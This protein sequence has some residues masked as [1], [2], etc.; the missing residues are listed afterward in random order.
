MGDRESRDVLKALE[1]TPKKEDVKDKK[2]HSSYGYNHHQSHGVKITSLEMALKNTVIMEDSNFQD[3]KDE[4]RNEE[5]FHPVYRKISLINGQINR[6]DIAAMRRKCKELNLNTFGKRDALKRRLKEYYKVEMLIEAGLIEEQKTRLGTNPDYFIVIDFEA[7]C[8]EKNPSGYPHEIIEFPAVLVSTSLKQIV[9]IFHSYVRPV[10]NPTLSEFCKTLTGIDQRVVDQSDPF[11]AVNG[12]FIQWLKDRQIG[13]KHS[14]ILITDG[15]FD[16][17]RFLYLQT[18]QSKIPYP[19]Y[20]ATSWSNLRKTFSNFYRMTQKKGSNEPKLPSLQCMLESLDL[21]FEG[22][23]HSGLDDSKNIARILIRLI[24]DRAIIRVNEKIVNVSPENEDD[25]RG[26][27]R[28]NN[29]VS[30]NRKEAEN[31]LKQ[32]RKVCLNYSNT[33][34][35]STSNR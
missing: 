8:E 30:V 6:M 35:H 16:M 32:Q 20:Y 22:S 18:K 4:N 34:D 2:S 1:R 13:T 14:F 5:Q 11:P 24:E 9:D 17:G 19:F 27:C 33:T 25:N 29:V 10:I 26:A 31:L 3:G 12:R 23:P 15:P 21:E 28:L 7:T